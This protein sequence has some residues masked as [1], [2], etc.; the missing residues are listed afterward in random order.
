MLIAKVPHDHGGKGLSS[1]TAILEIIL[2][3][4]RVGGGSHR[5]AKNSARALCSFDSMAGY[6]SLTEL[7]G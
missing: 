1:W 2:Y 7:R 6:E 3:G 4:G 5:A